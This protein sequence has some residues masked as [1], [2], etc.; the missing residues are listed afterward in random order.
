MQKGAVEIKKKQAARQMSRRAEAMVANKMEKVFQ[1]I[2]M[3]CPSFDDRK[4]RKG[5][6]RLEISQL[7]PSPSPRLRPVPLEN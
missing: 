3:L 6:N 2:Q 4:K 1:N 7:Q 5:A